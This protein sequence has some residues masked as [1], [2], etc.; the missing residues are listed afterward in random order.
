MS[1]VY[2]DLRVEAFEEDL[3]DFL[4][5][6]GKINYTGRIGASRSIKVNIDGDGSGYIGVKRLSDKKPIHEWVNLD[7]KQL[8]KVSDGED[9][10]DHYIGE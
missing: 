6:L 3:N 1:K 5:L 7:E 2:V 8:K 4:T 9:F 10:D